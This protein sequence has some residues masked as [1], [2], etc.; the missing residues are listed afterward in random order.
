MLF[1]AIALSSDRS[2]KERQKLPS[3]GT[4]TNKRKVLKKFKDVMAFLK[5]G[6]VH[7]IITAV[8]EMVM[9]AKGSKDYSETIKSIIYIRIMQ[10]FQ[11]P[12]WAV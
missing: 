2:I 8:V 6:E 9:E 7:S 12:D 10:N 11:V 1:S 4:K 5:K 3:L